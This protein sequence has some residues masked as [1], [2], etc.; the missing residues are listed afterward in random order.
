MGILVW[1]RRTEQPGDGASQAGSKQ[2]YNDAAPQRKRAGPNRMKE[3][4]TRLSRKP[5]AVS[6]FEAVAQMR[7]V[8]EH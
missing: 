8:Q 7:G 1:E 5:G 6:P 2:G 3:T 4:F